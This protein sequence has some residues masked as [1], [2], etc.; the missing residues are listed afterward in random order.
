[1][2]F[3]WR[4]L[5]SPLKRFDCCLRFG[6]RYVELTRRSHT[7]RINIIRW[8]NLDAWSEL[9]TTCHFHIKTAISLIV[10]LATSSAVRLIGCPSFFVVEITSRLG[11]TGL[12]TNACK[13]KIVWVREMQKNLSVKFLCVLCCCSH[14]RMSLFFY[15]F[16]MSILLETDAIVKIFVSANTTLMIGSNT[17]F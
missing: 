17:K 16:I 11:T 6:S 10:E 13:K 1:M 15:V 4:R 7:S 9:I 3:L 14:Q 12:G 8:S 2:L 5:L